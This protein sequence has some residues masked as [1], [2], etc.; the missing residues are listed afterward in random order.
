MRLKDKVAIITGSG[1]GIGRATALRFAEQ[2]ACIVVNYLQSVESGKQVVE[3]IIRKGGKAIG[4]RAD[5]SRKEDRKRLLDETLKEF[6]QIDIL[7]NNAGLERGGSIDDITEED[8]L[9]ITEVNVMAPFFLSRE[10]FKI[11]EKQ[12]KGKI[13]NVTSLTGI[14]PSVSNIVYRVSK[15][16]LIHLTKCLA[17]AFAPHIQVNG[18]A[19]G[20]MEHQMKGSGGFT[21][22]ERKARAQRRPL[23][24]LGTL[25][26]IA[27][28]FVY[29]ASDESN[30]I[31]GEVITFD[32]G[33]VI[34]S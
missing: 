18:I 26:E 2:G 3:E 11:M 4:V 34:A 10:A 31:T 16:A 22:E 15:S 29:L 9:R 28:L 20:M 13:I 32:G 8:W 17:L 1:R 30:Y 27:D 14:L 21:P 7:V 24:R 33:F 12:R 5:V 19:P 25:S 23:K 6:K